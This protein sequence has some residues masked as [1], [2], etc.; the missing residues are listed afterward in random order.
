M[1]VSTANPNKDEVMNEKLMF[2]IMSMK[3]AHCALCLISQLRDHVERVFRTTV[4]EMRET[5][6]TIGRSPSKETC[7]AAMADVLNKI[8][9]FESWVL[10]KLQALDISRDNRRARVP[11]GSDEICSQQVFVEVR[12]GAIDM[13]V[14]ITNAVSH[15]CF[16]MNYP[17]RVSCGPYGQD[18]EFEKYRRTCRIS[19]GSSPI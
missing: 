15:V 1:S 10:Q 17:N 12:N 2:D 7:D 16:D 3:D 14:F 5:H 8:D 13:F 9:Q 6:R 4:T 18:T 11:V 19:P